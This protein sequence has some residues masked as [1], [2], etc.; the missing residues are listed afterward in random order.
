MDWIFDGIGT[1]LVGLILGGAGGSA[2]TW[3]VVSKKQVQEQ[4][5]GD[6]SKQLMAGRDAGT[7]K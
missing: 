6:D 3:R 2:L 4:T 7:I 5:A 1:L